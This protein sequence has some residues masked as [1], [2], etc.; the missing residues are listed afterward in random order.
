MK[1]NANNCNMIQKTDDNARIKSYFIKS[2]KKTESF[3]MEYY[4]INEI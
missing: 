4:A 3:D 1:Y 2:L